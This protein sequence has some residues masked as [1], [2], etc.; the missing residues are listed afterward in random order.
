MSDSLSHWRRR[1][2]HRRTS[3]PEL[4]ALCASLIA[5]HEPRDALERHWVEELAFAAWRRL[6]LRRLETAALDRLAAGRSR[7][8]DRSLETFRRYRARVERDWRRA[9]TALASLR[10]DRAPAEANERLQDAGAD[11]RR[12]EPKTAAAKPTGVR[13]VTAGRAPSA[14][15]RPAAIPLA[16]NQNRRDAGC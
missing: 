16:A 3:D 2:D 1:A 14:R 5:R 9:E 12:N 8:G 4:A 7:P 10:A 13:L 6:L 15:R 11:E